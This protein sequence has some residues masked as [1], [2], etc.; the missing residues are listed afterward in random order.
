MNIFQRQRKL[1][2]LAAIAI[3]GDRMLEVYRIYKS[4]ELHMVG[5]Y[6]YPKYKRLKNLTTESFMKESGDLKI[7]VK[8]IFMNFSLQSDIV[9][10]C[11]AVALHSV[12][13]K[14]SRE[15]NARIALYNP[16][17]M[18]WWRAIDEGAYEVIQHPGRGFGVILG[19]CVSNSPLFDFEAGVVD[20]FIYMCAWL[21]PSVTT[22]PEFFSVGEDS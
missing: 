5:S 6:D 3:E 12:V 8:N 7:A 16:N 17:S 22:N 4:I 18:P 10:V 2:A 11:M 13:M 21:L 20:R 19:A 14:E 15:N 9:K 1:E